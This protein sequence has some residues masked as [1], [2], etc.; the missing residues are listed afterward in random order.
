MLKRKF[1]RVLAAGLTCASLLIPP[2]V[3]ASP[4]LQVPQVTFTVDDTLEAS[5]G[6]PYGKGPNYVT[7]DI[8]FPFSVTEGFGNGFSVFFSQQNIDFAATGTYNAKNVFGYSL[9]TRDIKDSYGLRYGGFPNLV[10]SAGTVYRHR[11]CC[12]SS[13]DPTNNLPQYYHGVFAG[14]DYRFGPSS[15]LGSK[16]F[17]LS[18]QWVHVEHQPTAFF[19]NTPSARNNSPVLGAVPNYN[20]G[21]NAV[22]PVDPKHGISLLGSETLGSDYYNDYPYPA[23][24]WFTQYGFQKRVNRNVSLQAFMS[25]VVYHR[26]GYPA[27]APQS[28]HHAEGHI[29]LTFS[30][31]GKRT[32]RILNEKENR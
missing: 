9:G 29:Q 19:L 4:N 8:R 11:V 20:F 15:G 13:D 31:G 18:A 23:Y 14:A 28:A 25:N 17:T 3:S 12:P 30:V 27:I 22:I 7:D 6:A 1:I 24:A 5:S 21:F 32:P 10:L 26:N 16:W 2:P